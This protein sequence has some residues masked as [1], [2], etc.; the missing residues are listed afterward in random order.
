MAEFTNNY[1]TVF[2]HGLMGFGETDGTYELFPYW[3]MSVMG[4]KRNL[5]KH[6]REEGYEVYAPNVGP[7][8]SAWD[9]AC[10]LWAQ[11][12]G[13]TVDYGK[14]H[15]EKYGHARYGRTYEKGLI[16][17]WGQEGDHK[18]INIIGHSFGGPSVKEFANLVANG[19]QEEVDG[20]PADE[21]SP[22]FLVNKP[23]KLHTATTLSGVNNGTMFAT[24]F[25]QKGMTFM[26]YL[27]LTMCIS[28]SKTAFPKYYDFHTD[29]WGAM[30]DPRFN[31]P[32]G[33]LVNPL[34][35]LDVM[36]AYNK[37]QVDS[38]A[39][40]MRV[41]LVQD[42]INPSQKVW[43]KTYYFARRADR[44]KEVLPS[45]F[46]PTKEMHPL[47][48][49]A[50]IFCGTWNSR[51]MK[52]QYNIGREWMPHDGFVNVIGQSAPL[53]APTKE[54]TAAEAIEPGIWY[55]MPVEY[56]DHVS[57]NGIGEHEGTYFQYYDEMMKLFRQLPDIK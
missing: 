23:Q 53:N 10:E 31:P 20:T 30:K 47:C 39:H 57:W 5:L 40:E 45:K 32:T 52:K 4:K 24:M 26:T 13:G 41:E 55:N 37:N 56:K 49:A 18:K 29:H 19:C 1:P 15:S 3:G 34:K 48:A 43:P 42:V 14:V 25:G 44:S 38:V 28:T 35:H 11:L 2:I 54:W 46:V 9:R 16:P 27:I 7:V 6:L 17:D 36:R 21:L 8:N 12:F 51:R 50:G 33:E 22:L